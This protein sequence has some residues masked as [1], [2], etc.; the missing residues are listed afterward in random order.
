MTIDQDII[1]RVLN[2][3]G[4]PQEAGEVARWLG[5]KEGQQ[6]LS[7]Q[8]SEEVSTMT[9]KNILEWTGGNIPTERMEKRFVNSLHR[10]RLRKRIW[11]A[12]AICLPFL[13]LASA[14]F[15]LADKV[16]VFA[17]K[18]FAEVT[19]PPG[20]RMQI[21]LQDGTTVE[22]NSATT[23]RY[24]RHFSLFNRQVELEGEAYFQVAQ[25]KGRPFI[26]QTPDLA[27]EVTG[28]RFNLK[29]Y[30]ADRLIYVA[31]DEGSVSLKGNNNKQYPMA[32]GETAIYD[33]ELGTCEIS[34]S[35]N[36][37]VIKAW[38][39]NSLS[40]YMTP[41]AEIIKILERQYDVHF[42]I[43][44]STLLSCRYTLST[45]KVNVADVLS[46]LE[47]VSHIKFTELAKENTFIIEGE[48]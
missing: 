31:L 13:L 27:V 2:N 35:I 32:C 7:R 42:I 8:L 45:D 36:T 1:N 22:L 28:T 37:D 40:F 15:F 26:I 33:R 44:D 43:P 25:E 46:D 6:F 21:I 16:G 39:T 9:E 5:T 19:V 29:A 47:K 17:E 10:K 14:T 18:Q 34:K 48:K 3:Q 23:L 38:R 30:P 12:A 20:E 24:P 41:L 4:S 11:M